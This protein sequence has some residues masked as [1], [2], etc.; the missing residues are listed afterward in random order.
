MRK[1]YPCAPYL[2]G[3]HHGSENADNTERPNHKVYLDAFQMDVRRSDQRDVSGM[4]RRGAALRRRRPGSETRSDYYGSSKFEDFPVLNVDWNQASAY[5]EWRGGSLPTEAQWEKAARGTDE[6][7]LPWGNGVSCDQVGYM[8]C[9]D[10]TVKVGSYESGMSPYGV[11]DMAGNVWEWVA[12]WYSETYYQNSS[13]E[14]PLGPENGMV[15]G[16]AAGVI[17]MKITCA[18]PFATDTPGRIQEFIGFRCAQPA[19]P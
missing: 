12:D 19:S 10:D 5:C 2:P 11:Y 14:N 17:I 15:R 13:Y 6:R 16:F 4:W 18:P 9:V 3:I 7:I 8:D 1:T